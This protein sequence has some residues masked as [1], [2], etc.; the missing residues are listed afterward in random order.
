MPVAALLDELGRRRLTNLLVEGGGQILGAFLDAGAV[1]AVDIYLAPLVEGGS[2]LFTPARG[3]GRPS[4][5]DALRLER[6]N[7]SLIDGD[8]RI[9]GTFS[10]SW[11][12]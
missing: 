5:A 7:V 3:T 9:Q 1:D 11:I 10:H 4:M 2:H 6:Q 12:P 8:V